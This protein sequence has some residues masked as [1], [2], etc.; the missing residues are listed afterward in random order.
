MYPWTMLELD[1]FSMDDHGILLVVDVTSQFPVVRILSN[2]TCKLV[3]NALKGIYCDFRLPRKV[4]SDN[5]LCFKVEEFIEFYTK[6][7]I[8]AEKASHTTTSL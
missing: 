5:G 1:L 7:G 4:L 8:T 2:E 3:L 6:L